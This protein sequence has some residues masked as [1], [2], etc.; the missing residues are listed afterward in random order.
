MNRA[1]SLSQLLQPSRHRLHG[2]FV[3]PIDSVENRGL[4]PQLPLSRHT[5]TSAIKHL[6][7]PTI[8]TISTTAATKHCAVTS[9][10]T[11]QLSG[12]TTGLVTCAQPVTLGLPNITHGGGATSTALPLRNSKRCEWIT[13]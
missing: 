11:P 6:L 8:V 7:P 3:I 2:G 1:R 9:T 5:S 12:T 13:T 10:S 4:R